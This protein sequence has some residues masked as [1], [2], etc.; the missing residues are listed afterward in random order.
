MDDGVAVGVAGP[1]GTYTTVPTGSLAP[2]ATLKN[3]IA[4]MMRLRPFNPVLGTRYAA[5][6]VF[7]PVAGSILQ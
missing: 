4:P 7:S 5:T 2:Q 3:V 1:G 6:L